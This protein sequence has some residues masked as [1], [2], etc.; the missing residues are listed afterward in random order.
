MSKD[1]DRLARKPL[2]A[3]QDVTVLAPNLG[4]IA[5]QAFRHVRIGRFRTAFADA[6]Q[7]V[8]KHPLQAVLV[9]VGLGYILSRTKVR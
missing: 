1:H 7:L 9:G 4:R 3:T 6:Q 5:A 8:R 2:D